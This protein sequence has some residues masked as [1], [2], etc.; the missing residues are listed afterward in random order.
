VSRFSARLRQ[1]WQGKETLTQ[2]RLRQS[3]TYRP[4]LLIL[5]AVV[6]TIGTLVAQGQSG[7]AS[8]MPGFDHG[9]AKAH[10]QGKAYGLE[11]HCPPKG[12]S[13]GV[14]KADFNGDGFADLAISEPDAPVLGRARAGDVIVLRGGPSGLSAT[15]H[16]FWDEAGIPARR[17]PKESRPGLRP[18]TASE[19][20]WRL[21]TSTA[22]A[23]PTWPSGLQART[24]PI[25]RS[26]V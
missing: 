18:T 7:S 25:P 6:L 22:T 21:A 15:A 13:S 14:A 17:S 19:G 24:S 10:P 8:D 16:Q 23:I 12:S 4:A 26:S 20:L 5:L 3:R 2:M 1:I 11:A 9:C